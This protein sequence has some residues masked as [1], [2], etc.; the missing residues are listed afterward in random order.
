MIFDSLVL[1]LTT[2]LQICSEFVIANFYRIHDNSNVIIDQVKLSYSEV[3][4]I[5]IEPVITFSDL[6]SNILKT[7]I[8]CLVVNLILISYYWRK[9][10][11]I[12]TDRFIRPSTCFITIMYKNYYDSQFNDCVLII[13]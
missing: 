5:Y 4:G 7:F 11:A 12:I 3:L 10:G 8:L 13:L 6:Q 1:N 9:Y 2:T